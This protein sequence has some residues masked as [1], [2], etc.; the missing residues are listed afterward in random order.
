MY[1]KTLRLLLRILVTVM[2]AV[3]LQAGYEDGSLRL[4][5]LSTGNTVVI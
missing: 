1:S 2:N 4:F 3:L 5:H